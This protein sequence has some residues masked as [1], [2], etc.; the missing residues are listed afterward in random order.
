MDLETA[1]Y[2]YTSIQIGW[3]IV[4]AFWFWRRSDEFP[5]I[6]SLF[7]F[8]VFAFRF[9][10]LLQGWATPVNISPFGFAPVAVENCLASHALG[11]LGE[12]MLL[13]VYMLAQNRTIWVPGMIGSAP[14]LQWLRTRTFVLVLVCA[15]LSTLTRRSVGAQIDAGKSMAFEISS[16]LSLFPMVLISGG[17][18]LVLLWKAGALKL[19]ANKAIACAM[20]GVIAYLTFDSSARFQFLGWILG[21]T[22]VLTAG[23]P[24][25]RKALFALLGLT[26][27]AALFAVA[28]TLRKTDDPEA[29]LEEESVNRF[30]FASDANML[31][32]FVLLRQVYPEMLPYS[33]GGEHL[34]ILTRPIPR[35]WWPDKP[36]GGYLNKLGIVDANTGFTLGISPSLFGS[37]YQEGG[38]IGVVI[39]SALYGFGF[40][41]LIRFSGVIHPL[42]G[43]L[44]RAITCAAVVPLLRGG[45]LPG[46]YAWFG[47]AFW[48]CL[49]ILYIWRKELLTKALPAA[50]TNSFPITQS[51]APAVS[52]R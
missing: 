51:F 36:V 37:F 43:L 35:A 1:F 29:V 4:S 14:F 6:L 52:T 20:L 23:L 5:L 7:L 38:T 25:R 42:G 12:T 28:G 16:Y 10:A 30:A 24:F 3:I 11:V 21:S 46:I 18:L 22:I 15:G 48:P 41:R 33:Y 9:W 32:G 2:L 47:M 8:Y 45:D 19:P 44:I 17:I 26:A 39:L 34:D 31:D 13:G 50:P 40:A 27:A 49:L